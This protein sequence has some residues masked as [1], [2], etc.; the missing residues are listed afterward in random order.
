RVFA[1]ELHAPNQRRLEA[2]NKAQ[3]ALILLLCVCPDGGK[4]SADLVAQ[5]ALDQI[6]IV[7]DKRWRLRSVGAPPD[8]SPQIDQEANIVS[9]ILLFRPGC[10]CT[11]NK[12][13]LRI[14]A[15]AQRNPLQA[16]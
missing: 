8:L 7:I 10:R 4:A 5:Y 1:V 3:H 11:D 9:Q 14:A 12:A 6:Q 16:M 13:A 2:A 15:F